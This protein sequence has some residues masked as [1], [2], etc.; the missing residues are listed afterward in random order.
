[1]NW[2]WNETTDVIE[3]FWSCLVKDQLVFK[4][5]K[6]LKMSICLSVSTSLKSDVKIVSEVQ[7]TLLFNFHL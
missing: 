1:M 3:V 6:V 2:K 7:A 5:K 4:L